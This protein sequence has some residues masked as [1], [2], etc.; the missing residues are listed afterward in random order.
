MAN[1]VNIDFQSVWGELTFINCE[2]PG[3]QP[4]ITVNVPDSGTVVHVIGSRFA[5]YGAGTINARIYNLGSGG[6]PKSWPQELPTKTVTGPTTYNHSQNDHILFVDT[7]GG[8]A[9]INLQPAWL[10]VPLIVKRKS[11]DTN[12]LQLVANGGDN[13]DGS[14]PY[15]MPTWSAGTGFPFLSLVGD[16]AGVWRIIG[17]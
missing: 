14:S 5:Q 8:A 3:S 6:F 10:G 4:G 17:K 2:F 1:A 12:T 7:T 16:G 13:I 15:T 9:T 11:S